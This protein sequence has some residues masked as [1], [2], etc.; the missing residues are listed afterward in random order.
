MLLFGVL[1]VINVL[2]VATGWRNGNLPGNEFRQTQTAISALFIQREN[3]F[4]LAYPTPVLGMPWSIPMEFPLYQWTVVVLSN[5][6]GMTLTSAGRAVSAACFYLALPALYLLLRRTGLSRPQSLLALG[7]VLSCPLYIF[8][9]RAFLIETM[10]LMFGLWYLL[11]LVKS[12]DG[13]WHR[14]WL[15]VAALMGTGAGLVKVTTFIFFLLPA[16]AWCLC[17]LWRD[18]PRQGAP[19]GW[20][21][22]ART[23][24]WLALL[25]ALPFAASVWWVEYSDA[26][27]LQNPAG[28]V[29]NSANMAGYNFGVGARFDPD[30]RAQQLAIL[31][32]EIATPIVLAA[33]ALL[34]VLFARRWWP[35]I[36]VCVTLFIAV[37]LLFPAL[38]A[39]H[40][41]YYVASAF[42][43][44]AALGFAL[45][46]AYESP[47][48]PR[49]AA[50]LLAIGVN[51]GQ[52][53]AYFQHHHPIQRTVSNGGTG[54]TDA[55]R[56][57]SAPDDVLVIA[58]E[59]WSSITPYFSERRA[60]MLR[61]RTERDLDMIHAAF[62][63][64]EGEAVTAVLLKGDQRE[65]D[66]LLK[67]TVEYFEIDPNPAMT[68]RDVTV[69]AHR[70][71]RTEWITSLVKSP[72]REVTPG[73]VEEPA[74]RLFA[75]TIYRYDE[76]LP[77]LRS[78]FR[79]MEPRPARFFSSVGPEVWDE[80]G[81]PLRFFAHPETRLWFR[82]YPGLRRLK[83][84]IEL[85]EN[86]YAGLPAHEASD[87]VELTATIVHDDGRREEVGRRH[88]N[89]RD[90]MAD[91]GPQAIDWSF[92]FPDGAEFEL[93]V[94]SGPE[95][96][97]ARD[98]ATLE[99][100]S[101]E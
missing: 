10:A 82:L 23:F 12:T 11:A 31:F 58:G 36:T 88:L 61:S 100:I 20:L 26:I 38:Y 74:P 78:V 37:Q 65:N 63:Q 27:K 81:R 30:I 4:S 60:L 45:A 72:H 22:F 67:L 98:W 51:A 86:T 53:S 34:A 59:D 96:N 16:L 35:H 28:S 92:P 91:R 66:Q 75:G 32:R 9:A 43:L 73:H 93:A 19:G 95:G 69:Y 29:L 94:T 89:P 2:G 99:Q 48:F 46:G 71:L 41:Y 56:E 3:N 77:R 55:L 14:G 17:L 79:T 13:G 84:V 101:I 7:L 33:G 40:E 68:W 90:T 42:T 57:L 80:P 62:D 97:A 70:Q 6:T 54:L 76:V 5:A 15:G 87:G 85:G 25:H 21:P 83:T 1:L 49:W 24:G 52:L 47:R 50:V 8:Y 18:R 64:L 44:M 39:W